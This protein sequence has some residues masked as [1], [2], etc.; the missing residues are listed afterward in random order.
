[1]SNRDPPAGETSAAVGP[2]MCTETEPVP[3]V[4]PKL[5]FHVP[6][7]LTV[8]SPAANLSLTLVR[9][10]RKRVTLS[11]CSAAMSSALRVAPLIGTTVAICAP[12]F[13][14]T[15]RRCRTT[16][17]RS[18][19]HTSELQSQ[20]NLVCRLLLEKKKTRNSPLPIPFSRPLC[21]SPANAPRSQL[22]AAR[23]KRCLSERAST[24]QD[25]ALPRIQT[26]LLPAT[27]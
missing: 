2:A 24:S 8:R 14:S 23:A 1:M 15:S 5:S 7:K 26:S 19:E 21:S 16:A 10:Y 13:G 20:S 18:E 25:I 9:S 17:S 3:G 6:A 12:E 11:F 27:L 4:L 22:T